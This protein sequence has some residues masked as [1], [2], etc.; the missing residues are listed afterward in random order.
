MFF[1]DRFDSRAGIIFTSF[2]SDVHPA[3]P[4]S[5]PEDDASAAFGDFACNLIPGGQLVLRRKIISGPSHDDPQLTAVEP[6]GA[7]TVFITCAAYH[8]KPNQHHYH[9]YSHLS[10]LTDLWENSTLRRD[11][12]GQR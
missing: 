3:H 5:S 1:Q 11:L 9:G 12:P 2:N 7:L 4:S 10:F 6:A 8:H